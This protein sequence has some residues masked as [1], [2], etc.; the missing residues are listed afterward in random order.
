[1]FLVFIGFSKFVRYSPPAKSVFNWIKVCLQFFSGQKANFQEELK[2]FLRAEEVVIADAW[3]N[4]L[5]EGLRSL[6]RSTQKEIIL[7]AY[8]CNEFYKAILLADLVPVPVDLTTSGTLSLEAVKAAFNHNTLAL[9]AVN[10]TGVCSDL[11]ALRTFCDDSNIWMVED[12]GYTLFGLEEG[13]KPFGSFGHASIINMSEGKIIPVGGA[14]WV[15]N[16]QTLLPAAKTFASSIALQAA[17]GAA[18]SLLKLLIYR[19][20]S[21][22]WG[23]AVYQQAKAWGLGDLKAK[24]T[25]EPSRLGEDY[26]SGNLIWASG[27]LRL[28]PAHRTQLQQIVLRPWSRVRHLVAKQILEN[29]LHMAASRKKQLMEVL[30]LLPANLEPMVLPQQGMPVKLPVLLSMPLTAEQAK[31]LAA[32]GFKKQYPPSWPMAQWPYPNSK[33]FY[34]AI[35][36]WPIHEGIT[37]KMRFALAEQVKIYK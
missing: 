10:N 33:R 5:A 18:K 22:R 8:A 26:E 20:G 14:A 23:F 35:Y 29:R 37:N 2:H 9:L 30:A 1:M 6:P 4:L 24:F 11:K 17:E 19:L 32:F 7:P 36:T 3:V 13:G 28:E 12:A 31:D 21:S 27:A 16:A 25:S 15:V 34:Q